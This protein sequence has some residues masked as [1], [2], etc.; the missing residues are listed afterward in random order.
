MQSE[1]DR[2]LGKLIYF[3]FQLFNVMHEDAAHAFQAFLKF[4]VGFSCI[5]MIDLCISKTSQE[6]E[7]ALS[8]NVDSNLHAQRK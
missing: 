3:H 8:E 7:I 4:R 2:F 6:W 5:E 1:A